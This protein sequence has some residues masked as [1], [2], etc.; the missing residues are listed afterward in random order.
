MAANLHQR[1]MSN[2]ARFG[3]GLHRTDMSGTTRPMTSPSDPQANTRI[4]CKPVLRYPETRRAKVQNMMSIA[5]TDPELVSIAD[6]ADGAIYHTDV[7][8]TS[9]FD[10]K[11]F[12]VVAFFQDK[13]RPTTMGQGNMGPAIFAVTN[14]LTTKELDQAKVYGIALSN[15]RY[16]DAGNDL[17]TNNTVVLSGTHSMHHNGS[18]RIYPQDIVC[19]FPRGKTGY[20]VIHED[21][22]QRAVFV[23][24]PVRLC[25]LS[26][27]LHKALNVARLAGG[28]APPIASLLGSVLTA[29]NL[30]FE[31]KSNPY[32]YHRITNRIMAIADINNNDPL[33]AALMVVDAIE[34]VKAVI[35]RFRLGTAIKSCNPGG[36]LDVMINPL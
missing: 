10:I 19:A 23:V 15:S 13:V 16:D 29:A 1:A 31:E 33:E 25:N 34:S 8:D 14:G 3:G 28:G 35:K 6:A 32:C 12:N 17:A 5:E 27:S 22:K 2:Q 9:I 21:D 4:S 26:S 24:H 18:Q 11:E 36:V 20:K 30:N 7:G